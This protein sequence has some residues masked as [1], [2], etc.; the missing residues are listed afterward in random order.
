MVYAATLSESQKVMRWRLI[1]EDFGPNTQQIDGVDKILAAKI[2]RLL[3]T[4]SNKYKPCTMKSQCCEKEIFAIGEV[5]N[6]EDFF[7]LNI[8]IVQI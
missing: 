1:L 4:P 6:N 8:L 3:S 2:S 7:P 5:E